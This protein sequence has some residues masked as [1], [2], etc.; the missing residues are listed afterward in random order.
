MCPKISFN[1]GRILY[2]ISFQYI[3]LLLLIEEVDSTASAV[4][5]GGV[6]SNTL[7]CT[8]YSVACITQARQYIV[9]LV[10]TLIESSQIDIN[11]GVFVHY[12]LYTLR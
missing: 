7:S 5:D 11:I 12:S 3:T 4:E 1:R 8:E 9:L 2:I 10:Q 6:Q